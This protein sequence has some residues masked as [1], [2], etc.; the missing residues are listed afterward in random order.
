M[1]KA[2]TGEAGSIAASSRRG[3]LTPQL[4]DV[5]RGREAPTLVLSGTYVAARRR[6]APVML[7]RIGG[8]QPRCRRRCCPRPDWRCNTGLISRAPDE[9]EPQR[10]STE[11]QTQNRDQER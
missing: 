9:Q 7:V 5:R 11:D 8:E 4:E 10:A 1:S 6:H 3:S 2:T